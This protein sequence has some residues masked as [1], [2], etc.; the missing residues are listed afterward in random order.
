[1]REPW[2]PGISGPVLIEAYHQ[3]PGQLILRRDQDDGVTVLHADPAIWL[4][5]KLM[6]RLLAGWLR[7]P[8]LRMDPPGEYWEPAT[9]GTALMWACKVQARP[10][11]LADWHWRL[12]IDGTNQQ[13]AYEVTGY[14]PA[15]AVPA[16]PLDVYRLAWPD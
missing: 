9:P 13:V 1:M 7:A 3:A 11:M 16:P 2:G 10:W 12:R 5:V 14:L 15:A 6:V 8:Q 4:S